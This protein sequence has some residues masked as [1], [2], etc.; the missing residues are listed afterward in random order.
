M[1]RWNKNCDAAKFILQDLQDEKI[2]PKAYSAMEVWNSR[3]EYQT[4]KL[5]KF[6]QNLSRMCKK[7]C[8]DMYESDE[9][10]GELSEIDE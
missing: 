4:W 6:S 9:E 8:Q 5:D 10:H 7:Y 2:D 1:S 3:P